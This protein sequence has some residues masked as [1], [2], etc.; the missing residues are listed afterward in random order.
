MPIGKT[1]VPSLTVIFF[2][3]LFNSYFFKSEIFHPRLK[4]FLLSILFTIDVITQISIV[5]LELQ[6]PKKIKH[7]VS[8]VHTEAE[9]WKFS[10]YK[11]NIYY[12]NFQ[13]NAFQSI[14]TKFQIKNYC[15]NIILMNY[16]FLIIITSWQTSRITENFVNSAISGNL[17]KIFFFR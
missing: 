14:I 15:M 7:P 8:G 11:H 5:N 6:L 10:T 13:S 3:F 16:L 17:V 1:L 12:N 4:K 9:I 2:L